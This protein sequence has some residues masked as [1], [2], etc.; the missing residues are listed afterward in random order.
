MVAKHAVPSAQCLSAAD[1][2]AWQ[3]LYISSVETYDI[4]KQLQLSYVKPLL[5]H[6]PSLLESVIV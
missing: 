5:S 4:G 1:C 2:K 6:A 3:I